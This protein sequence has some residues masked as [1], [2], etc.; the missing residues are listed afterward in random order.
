MADTP[1]PKRMSKDEAMYGFP[2]PPGKR[3][4]LCISSHFRDSQMG[5]CDK[6]F[7]VVDRDFFCEEFKL[8]PN[9]RAN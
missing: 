7:G 1:E 9:A 4:S 8:R 5:S 6:V 2:T 3:C